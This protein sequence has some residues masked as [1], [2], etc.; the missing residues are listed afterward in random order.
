MRSRIASYTDDGSGTTYTDVEPL[1]T[2]SLIAN[3]QMEYRASGRTSF[4][5]ASRYV[6]KSQLANDGN[7]SLVTPA[8]WMFDAGV[9]WRAGR[10]ETRA[11]LLNL[12]DTKANAGG[13]T[14]GTAR[15]FYPLAGRNVLVTVHVTY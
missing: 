11:Q 2:P 5:F 10:L 3:Q 7:A 12:A 1:L 14:D 15:Y 9:A 13:Y 8:Y 6:S 4:T